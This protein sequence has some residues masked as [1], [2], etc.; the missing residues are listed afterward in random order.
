MQEYETVEDEIKARLSPCPR[1][2]GKAELKSELT[3]VKLT[4]GEYA[5][6]NQLMFNIGKYGYMIS[7]LMPEPDDEEHYMNLVDAWWER[8]EAANE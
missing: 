5:A 4:K 1:C 8:Q 3:T 2:G 7:W 6:V